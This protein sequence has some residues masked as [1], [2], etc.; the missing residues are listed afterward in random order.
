M[1]DSSGCPAVTNAPSKQPVGGPVDNQLMPARRAGKQFSYHL[2]MRRVGLLVFGVGLGAL[3]AA[4]TTRNPA[5]YCDNGICTDPQYPFCDTDGVI[6]GQPKTCIAVSCSP[7]E[8]AACDG[9]SALT[10]SATGNDYDT[11]PCEHGC[12]PV[13]GCNDC[14]PG[15]T[16]CVAGAVNQCGQD[17][18]LAV[19]EQCTLDCVDAPAP[20]CAYI[21]PRYVPDVC[22]TPAPLS[23]LTV[24][25][26]G[27]L[28]PNLDSNCTGGVIAQTGGPSICVV[29]Y[30]TITINAGQTLTVAG[31]AQAGIGRAV[32][33][34]EDGDLTVTGIL[35]VS[36]HG[37][38][39]GP[40][41]GETT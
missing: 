6:G 41:G 14:T 38:T 9:D 8:F 24:T 15:T 11:H 7:M 22:D 26:S 35:D 28:D 2:Y 20:H 37:F 21:Q 33:L 32:A 40:G 1:F 16:S 31:Y 13:G 39:N 18:K 17:G 5:S 25:S 27:T 10:C 12:N 30:S 34:V 19:A 23:A 4:C 36:A 29:H 3:V